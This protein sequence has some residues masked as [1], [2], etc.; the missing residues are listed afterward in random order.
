MIPQS[1][2]SGA[3]S[4]MKWVRRLGKCS[5]GVAADGEEKK[6]NQAFG[7]EETWTILILR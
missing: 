7:A 1:L 4:Q 3:L 5:K 6:E 2:V